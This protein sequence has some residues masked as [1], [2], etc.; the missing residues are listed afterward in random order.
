MQALFKK[1]LTKLSYG[2]L[3]GTPSW[4]H[5]KSPEIRHERVLPFCSYAPWVNDQLSCEA[6]AGCLGVTP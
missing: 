3:R 4:A 2:F 1:K 5:A 6:G